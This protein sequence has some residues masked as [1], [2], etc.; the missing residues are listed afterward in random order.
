MVDM[1]TFLITLYVIDDLCKE[2]HLDYPAHPG[3][4]ASLACSEVVSLALFGQWARFQYARRLTLR[5]LASA[6][7]DVPLT[8]SNESSSDDVRS[9]F[10]L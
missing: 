10:R 9:L 7:N 1:D 2:H 3:P 8:K 4:S 5:A 6:S